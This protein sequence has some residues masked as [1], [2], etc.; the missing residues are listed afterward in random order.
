MQKYKI[1]SK[2]LMINPFSPKMSDYPS[3]QQ[4]IHPPPFFDHPFLPNNFCIVPCVVKKKKNQLETAF[5][6]LP[7]SIKK[8]KTKQFTLLMYLLRPLL[9]ED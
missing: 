8:I 5:A 7:H 9:S 1:V 4:K 6:R 2:T 3:L